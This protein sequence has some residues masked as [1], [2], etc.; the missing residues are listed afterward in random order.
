[1][2]IWDGE[3][4]KASSAHISDQL[5]ALWVVSPSSPLQLINHPTRCFPACHPLLE[6]LSHSP[7]YK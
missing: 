7:H 1:M 3:E 2:L 5:R 6:A 4:G